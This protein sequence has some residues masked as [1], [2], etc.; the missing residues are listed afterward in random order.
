M[1]QA[2]L[3][4]LAFTGAL[5]Q[6]FVAKI[7]PV[8]ALLS[9]SLFFIVGVGGISAFLGH[10]LKLK[11]RGMSAETQTV[12]NPKKLLVFSSLFR[13]ILGLLC[14]WLRGNF[15]SVAVIISAI[16]IFWHGLY[17]FKHIEE[18][19]TNESK[20]FYHTD[21]LVSFDLLFPAVLI[22]LLTVYKTGI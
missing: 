19:A 16:I 3:I 20:P 9:N 22:G 17:E 2:V 18:T 15:W 14:V 13:G 5:I 8:E 4:I 12:S 1:L 6:V 7:T 21:F 11:D 10:F